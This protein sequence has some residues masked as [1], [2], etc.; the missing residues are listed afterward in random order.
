MV[1]RNAEKLRSPHYKVV[2]IGLEIDLHLLRDVSYTETVNESFTEF[3][4]SNKSNHHFPVAHSFAHLCCMTDCDP[5]V[6]TSTSIRSCIDDAVVGWLQ[7]TSPWSC[8]EQRSAPTNGAAS[9][10]E[11]QERILYTG[12]IVD[13]FLYIWR[14]N[15]YTKCIYKFICVYIY[16]TLFPKQFAFRV[17]S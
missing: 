9:I 12:L 2:D 14:Y 8:V 5:Y 7:F 1:K 15:C 16:Y 3:F 6:F 10:K 13:I 17:S 4:S 11:G